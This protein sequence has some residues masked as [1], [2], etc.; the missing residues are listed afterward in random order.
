MKIKDQELWD[1]LIEKNKD[2]PYGARILSYAKDWADLMEKDMAAGHTLEWVAEE[3]STVADTDGIT[4]N[5]YGM[6]VSIL[7][8]AWVHGEELRVWHNAQ[9]GQASD[10]GTVNPAMLNIGNTKTFV[11]G[12][13]SDTN[14]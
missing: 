4:L 14:Q 9:Y 5:M 1:S 6:A 12:T 11:V 10:K 7:S 3:A 2:E 8:K 13:K